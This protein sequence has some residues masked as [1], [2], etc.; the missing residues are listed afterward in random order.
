M[1]ERSTYSLAVA[2]RI[3]ALETAE[4]FKSRAKKADLKAF[5][6]ILFRSGGEKPRE[7]DELTR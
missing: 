1:S 3:S 7:K 4:F 5:G 6:D 2:K